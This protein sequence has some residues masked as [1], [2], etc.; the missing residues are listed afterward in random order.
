V[1]YPNIITIHEENG[2]KN[3]HPLFNVGA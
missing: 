3:Y 2:S 1:L